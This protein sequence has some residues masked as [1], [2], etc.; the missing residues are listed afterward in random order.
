MKNKKL[1]ICISF[2]AACTGIF[3]FALFQ[4]YQLHYNEKGR[5]FDGV[6]IL[7]HDTVLVLTISAV[8]SLVATVVL[9]ILYIKNKKNAT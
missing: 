3:S 4:R 2:F 5:Y 7:N 8:G 1:I 6:T 9:Y